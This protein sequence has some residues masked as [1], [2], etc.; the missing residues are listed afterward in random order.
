MSDRVLSLR[1]HGS[2]WTL[3]IGGIIL[4]SDRASWIL[5]AVADVGVGCRYGVRPRHVRQHPLFDEPERTTECP[6]RHQGVALIR[7]SLRDTP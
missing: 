2:T 5:A 6:H 1:G 7:A 4:V 3:G